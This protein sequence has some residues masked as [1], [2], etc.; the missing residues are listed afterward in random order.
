[1]LSQQKR[2]STR[3]VKGYE[4][5]ETILQRIVRWLRSQGHF[6]QKQHGS[7]YGHAGEPDLYV[8]LRSPGLRVYRLDESETSQ[9]TRVSSKD[10]SETS[11]FRRV[12]PCITSE[13]SPSP[14]VSPCILSETSHAATAF[15]PTRS[16]F[17]IPCHF[18]VKVPGQ[19]STPLQRAR[20]AQ[21]RRA[22]ALVAEVH[23]LEEVQEVLAPLTTTTEDS[24]AY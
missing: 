4:R 19:H 6:V 18:E 23:S 1:M 2:A 11:P 22:G 10:V 3:L 9:K 7:A 12:S 24:H 20:Q 13:L 21:L 5:E 15:P 17:A 16:G 14:G 8:L